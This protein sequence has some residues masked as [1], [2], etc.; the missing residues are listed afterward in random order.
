MKSFLL[1]LLLIMFAN[2]F[3]D[4]AKEIMESI[5]KCNKA[6][7]AFLTDGKELTVERINIVYTNRVIS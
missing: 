4:K 1:V 2:G 6:A 5:S 3:S 7:N